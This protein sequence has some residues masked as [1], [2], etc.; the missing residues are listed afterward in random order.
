MKAKKVMLYCLLALVAGCGPILSLNPLFTKE[1]LVFDEKLLGTWVGDAN[2]PNMS[3]EFARLD[4]NS[5]GDLPKELKGE[6]NRVYQMTLFQKGE[7]KGV[8][9]A[10]LVKLGDRRFLDVFPDRYPSGE[11]DPE[12]TKLT[13]NASF[14]LRCHMFA[15]VDAI[16]DH[17]D[18][19]LTDDEGLKKLV[20]AEPKAVAYATTEE[21]PVLTASTQ[22]LQAF[23]TKFAADERLFAGEVTFTRKTK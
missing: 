1:N 12:E 3:L 13:F 21:G 11:S 22:E 8:L 6:F 9:V 16:G 14:F 20:E 4:E 7:R 10:C 19:H 15:R 5:A 17:L 18:I 23:V 2:D